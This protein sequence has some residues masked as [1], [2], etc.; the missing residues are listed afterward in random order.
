MEAIKFFVEL[1]MALGAV[2]VIAYGAKRVI[3]SLDSLTKEVHGHG[4]KIA[5]LEAKM[6]NGEIKIALSCLG[7]LKKAVSRVRSELRALRREFRDHANGEEE[8][9]LEY[10][11][12][13]PMKRSGKGT[14]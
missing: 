9:I 13:Q 12:K 2:F 7:A 1:V 4:E 5:S 3:N 10:L 14:V 8:R 11:R 6:P